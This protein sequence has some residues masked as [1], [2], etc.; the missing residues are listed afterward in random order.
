MNGSLTLEACQL[1]DWNTPTLPAEARDVC[2]CG[3]LCPH[4]NPLTR[5]AGE[6]ADTGCSPGTS[7]GGMRSPIRS[8]PAPEQE[9]STCHV[10]H[11]AQMQCLLMRDD[12]PSSYS[13]FV[14]HIFWNIERDA[15]IEPPIQAAYFRSGG[16]MTLWRATPAPGQG[17]EILSA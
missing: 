13:S 3:E 14:T 4:G 12:P 17:L 9:D 7:S 15:R 5:T 16:A 1:L 11:G 8:A 2:V 6:G 10:S